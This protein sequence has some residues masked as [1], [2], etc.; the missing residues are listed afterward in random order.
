MVNASPADKIY[1]VVQIAA[2][3][4]TLAAEG[5]AAEHILRGLHLTESA[6]KSP[7][8]R[9]SLNQ[10]LQCL[11]NALKLTKDPGFAY[12]TGLR[13]HATAFGMYGFAILS[14]PDFRQTIHFGLKYHALAAPLIGSDF[15]E[16]GDRVI[17]TMAPLPEL[18]VDERLGLALCEY[19]IAVLITL[20]RDVMGSTFR[21]REVQLGYPAPDQ[22]HPFPGSK[23]AACITASPPTGWCTTQAGSTGCRS[24]ETNS[25]T[26]WS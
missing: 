21:A 18:H 3:V 20:H 17:W 15:I 19:S 10:I 26:P 13:M 14:S 5:V 6:L 7:E 1:P 24:S 22:P 16:E 9:V 11:R 25:R 2:M 8:T 23:G 4:D 12:R